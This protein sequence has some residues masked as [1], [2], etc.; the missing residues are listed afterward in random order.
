MRTAH[1][2]AKRCEVCGT[3]AE[4][5]YRGADNAMHDLCVE[6]KNKRPVPAMNA[7]PLST[8]LV[9]AGKRQLAGTERVN[10]LYAVL[11]KEWGAHDNIIESTR[12][13]LQARRIKIGSLL[14]EIKQRIDA[15]KSVGS[16]NGL[17]RSCPAARAAMPNA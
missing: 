1:A 7:G 4:F 10:E 8:E 3:D 12:K 14:L 6:H 11:I 16:G 13:K 15:G 2:E 5:R 17:T 9:K